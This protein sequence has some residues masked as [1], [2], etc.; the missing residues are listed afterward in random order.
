[1]V[2]KD[3]IAYF[4]KECSGLSEHERSEVLQ[5]LEPEQG[6]QVFMLLDSL[7]E[8]GQLSCE[9]FESTLKGFYWLCR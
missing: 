9:Q 4:R 1:M 5:A 3:Y 2:Y 6:P 7:L 8:R